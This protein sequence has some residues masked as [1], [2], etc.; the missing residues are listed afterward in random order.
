MKKCAVCELESPDTATRCTTCGWRLSSRRAYWTYRLLTLVLIPAVLWLASILWERVERNRID[1]E[2]LERAQTQLLEGLTERMEGFV[3]LRSGLWKATAPLGRNC[4]T[5]PAG[6]GVTS[7][8]A[9]CGLQSDAA[10][11]A[12]D[13]AIVDL[14]WRVDSL[15]IVSQTTYVVLTALKTT[16]WKS[17]EDSVPASACG[18]RQRAVRLIHGIGLDPGHASLKSCAAERDADPRC[19]NSAALMRT[20]VQEPID[21]DANT[22]FCLVAADI[23]DARVSVF[24]R[25]FAAIS[26]DRTLQDLIDRLERNMEASSCSAIVEAWS[27]EHPTVRVGPAGSK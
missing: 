25:R 20:L 23:K 3:A 5:T 7:S 4:A 22:F 15:P 2:E 19:K 26:G 12:V 10:L 24:K 18:Y 8:T 9:A 1:H 16:Y 17:C 21:S 27:R 11:H 6:A 14:A 13:Q